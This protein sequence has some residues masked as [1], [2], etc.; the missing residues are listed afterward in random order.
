MAKFNGSAFVREVFLRSNPS[1][2]LN[3]VSVEHPIKPGDYAIKKSEYDA[4]LRKYGVIDENG[5]ATDPDLNMAVGFWL[6]NQGPNIVK[7]N[8]KA[9]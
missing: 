9:A 7:D 4:I 6:L 5:I 3:E 1:V 8:S 2:D